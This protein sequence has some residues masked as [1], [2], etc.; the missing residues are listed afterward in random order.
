MGAQR[1]QVILALK[2]VVSAERSSLGMTIKGWLE[3]N[4]MTE[5]L[6]YHLER[7]PLEAVLPGLL[8]RSL[9]RGWRALVK[10]GSE[11]RLEALSGH[12]WTF[13]DASFLPHGSAADGHTEEQPV[14][15]TTGDDNP[16]G[17]NVR[18]LVDG[19]DVPELIGYDRTV[20]IFDAAESEA[21]AKAREAWK[22]ASAAGHDATY[23]RQDERGRWVKQG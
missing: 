6:F 10:V 17:A 7:R 3:L 4:R 14:W 8:Q 2:T 23:W 21:V 11:E 5:V 9:E 18:F 20:F 15:L 22:A 19:A 12:L 16:N 1:T 13:D